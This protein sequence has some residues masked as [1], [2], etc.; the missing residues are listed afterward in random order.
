MK[1]FLD[2][3]LLF[4]GPFLA[5][6]LI[7]FI[8]WRLKPCRIN[9]EQL[10]GLWRAGDNVIFAAWHD[11]LLMLPPFYR[12]KAAKALIS[13]SKDGELIARTVAY[14]SISSVRGSSSRGG[15]EALME[16]KMLAEEPIDLAITPDGPRGPRHEVKPGVVQ[17]A[18]V[19]GRP[20]VPLA[21]ACSHGYR[22]KSW[23][24]FLLPYPW[25][26]AVYHVGQ[27][28]VAQK[29]ESVEELQVRVQQALNDNTRRATD[30]LEKYD[31]SA[32]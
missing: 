1:R 32:V 17:L 8:H 12:G 31:L 20:V 10:E 29:H 22:F 9:Y 27:P 23:D 21:F 7:R 3:L 11:Q 4:A 6:C 18:K 2:R 28:V 5:A 15:R 26:K 16:L 25:G 14:F 30:Y 19:S 13:A 24:R